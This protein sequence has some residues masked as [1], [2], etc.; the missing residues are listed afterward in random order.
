M[1]NA[2]FLYSMKHTSYCTVL[3]VQYAPASQFPPFNHQ[4]P[5]FIPQINATVPQYSSTTE[6][7]VVL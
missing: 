1:R 3:V 2:S 6:Y 5:A 7:T 4:N